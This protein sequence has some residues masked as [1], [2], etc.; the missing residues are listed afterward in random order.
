[1]SSA[2][3]AR[4]CSCRVTHASHGEPWSRQLARYSSWAAITSWL[5]AP[6]ELVARWTFFSK[7]G[8]CRRNST[9]LRPE[10]PRTACGWSAVSLR[11]AGVDDRRMDLWL[12]RAPRGNNR[13]VARGAD[14]YAPI[15]DYAVIGD[16]RTSALVA[17]D[18]SIDSPRQRIE[19]RLERTRRFWQSWSGQ[20]RYDGPWR[21]Q[22]IR[23]HWCSS[24][25]STPR[26]ARSSPRRR[27]RSRN[28]RA[29]S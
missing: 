25:S 3:E 19:E 23:A 27:L 16:G 4:S 13:P 14:G 9:A 1:M 15:G 26:P 12:K 18:G 28:S 29:A 22:V 11:I 7:I 21:D 20:A 2:N 6:F 5:S 10:S 24:C 8:K 17:A